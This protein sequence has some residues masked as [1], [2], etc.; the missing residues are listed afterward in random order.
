MMKEDVWV[1]CFVYEVGLHHLEFSQLH[2]YAT[3]HIFYC[4]FIFKE[5]FLFS[6]KLIKSE[7]FN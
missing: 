1:G 7:Y 6:I 4:S 5:Y 3:V 2:A